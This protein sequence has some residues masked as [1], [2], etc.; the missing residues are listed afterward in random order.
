LAALTDSASAAAFVPRDAPFAF[1][2]ARVTTGA[3]PRAAGFAPAV[4]QVVRMVTRVAQL[5]AVVSHPDSVATE[6]AAETQASGGFV[7]DARQWHSSGQVLA[8]LTLRVPDDRLAA[9][10][11]AIR[12][13]ALRVD[14]ENVTGQDVTEEYTDLGA[15]I[16]NLRATE[17]ELRSLLVTVGERTKKAADV[18]EV[19]NQLTQVR[20]QIEQAQA[21][22]STLSKLASLATINVE[23]VPDALTK[24]LATSGWRPA[25]AAHQ[26]YSKLTGTL[27]WLVDA[28]IWALIYILPVIALIA[29]PAG[30][31]FFGVRGLRRRTLETPARM[32]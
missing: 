7:E 12:R 23:L 30:V 16:T 3:L 25:V 8:S 6:L 26:A 24:P 1:S 29:V 32:S 4:S 15:Q 22:L 13:H 28:G 19:F 31:L 27:R 17:A 20:G 18:L 2:E 21:R 10:L 9:T 11:D 5:R 14:E